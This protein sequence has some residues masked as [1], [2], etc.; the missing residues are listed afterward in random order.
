MKI[1]LINHLYNINNKISNY[2]FHIYQIY[3]FYMQNTPKKFKDNYNFY[4]EI[5]NYSILLFK[6]YLIQLH[7]Y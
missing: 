3:F 6:N 2:C 4:I 7:S 1:K 5:K